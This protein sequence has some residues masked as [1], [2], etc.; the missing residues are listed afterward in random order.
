MKDYETKHVQSVSEWVRHPTRSASDALKKRT[1]EKT[2]ITHCMFISSLSKL[3]L[4][5]SATE[6]FR[7]SLRSYSSCAMRPIDWR[8]QSYRVE[9]SATSRLSHVTTQLELP[10]VIIELSGGRYRM[11][12]IGNELCM[13]SLI[14]TRLVCKVRGDWMIGFMWCMS[15]HEWRGDWGWLSWGPRVEL[16]T[17]VAS[18]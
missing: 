4:Y 11:C 8:A 6:R 13:Q 17:V 7:H 2:K 10:W 3:A 14:G 5:R 1:H 12:V 9:L 18:I 16:E 15:W